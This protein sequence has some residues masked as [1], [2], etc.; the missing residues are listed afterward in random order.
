MNVERSHHTL[1][2]AIASWL[3][4]AAA[5]VMG[6]AC[7]GIIEE[8]RRSSLEPSQPARLAG[9][10]SLPPAF[11]VQ[12]ARQGS[13]GGAGVVLPSGALPFVR[14]TRPTAVSARG[15]ELYVADAVLAGVYRYDFA[16]TLAVRLTGVPYQPDIQ[17]KV[18]ADRTL[19]VVD[20]VGRRVVRV[21]P[22]GRPIQDLGGGPLE[23]GRP[24]DVAADV[25]R[26][27]ILIA[28]GLLR[29]LLEYNPAGRGF[30]VVPLRGDDTTQ[31]TSIS[32]IAAGARAWYVADPACRCVLMV[33]ADGRIVGRIGAGEVDQVAGMDVD[34][35]GRLFVADNGDRMLKVFVD[36][37][38]TQSFSYRS[39][40]VSE[41]GDLEV[42][43]TMLVLSDPTA[44]VVEVRRI[45]PRRAGQGLQ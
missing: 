45:A 12:G 17:L 39:I 13:L 40:G 18:L 28:D 4:V 19:L 6:M 35:A 21:T 7:S 42:D 38:L 1:P 2:G 37:R 44:G 31:V 29:Q 14:F 24:V 30:R 34:P 3:L 23:L 16:T 5:A 10:V 41:V 43:D 36:G 11:T 22:D 9:A 32:A 15:G 20:G 33:A 26:G 8:A 25:G 27:R